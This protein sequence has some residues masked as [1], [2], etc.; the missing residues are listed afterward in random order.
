MQIYRLRPCRTFYLSLSSSFN[1]WADALTGHIKLTNQIEG[2]PGLDERGVVNCA[3]RSLIGRLSSHSFLLL[4]SVPLSF[5]RFTWTV[6]LDEPRQP[7][8][9]GV[10][11][12]IWENASAAIFSKCVFLSESESSRKIFSPLPSLWATSN[13]KQARDWCACPLITASLTCSL[14]THKLSPVHQS[15]QLRTPSFWSLYLFANHSLTPHTRALSFSVRESKKG[16]GKER[17]GDSRSLSAALSTLGTRTQSDSMG[18]QHWG[19]KRW[20]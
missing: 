15:A 4:Y 3:D 9:K 8:T 10:M 12:K 11:D 2:A 18:L 19:V 20:N 6:L 13:H 7:E 17:E 1:T 14:R 16:R 5:S